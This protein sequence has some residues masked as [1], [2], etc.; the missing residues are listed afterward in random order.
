MSGVEHWVEHAAPYG[1]RYQVC[2][3]SSRAVD[4]R[5]TVCAYDALTSANPQSVAMRGSACRGE[6]LSTALPCTADAAR[7]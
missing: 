2:T 7:R 4:Q 5:H 1:H 3:R 6:S